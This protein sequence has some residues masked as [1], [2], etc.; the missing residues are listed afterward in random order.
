MQIK[1]VFRLLEETHPQTM[2]EELGHYPPFQLLVMTML[3]ARSK[4]STVIPIVKEMFAKYPKPEDYVNMDSEKLEKMI[5]KI[6][7][8]KVKAK[9]LKLLSAMKC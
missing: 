6:G 8:Y 9:H 3:S 1:K 2:L 5:Y 7:F 4:D